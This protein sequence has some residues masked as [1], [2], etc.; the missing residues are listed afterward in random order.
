MLS[1]WLDV[2]NEAKSVG[3][4]LVVFLKDYQVPYLVVHFEGRKMFGTYDLRLFE[5]PRKKI[6]AC[7]FVS[8]IVKKGFLEKKIKELQKQGYNIKEGE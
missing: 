2:Y 7:E 1:K 5:V 3:R 4:F 8:R 6:V